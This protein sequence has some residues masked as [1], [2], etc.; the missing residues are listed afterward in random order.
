MPINDC[1]SIKLDNQDRAAVTRGPGKTHV[2]Q[3][4]DRNPTITQS[5][6]LEMFTH[7]NIVRIG[8]LEPGSLLFTEGLLCSRPWEGSTCSL[9]STVKR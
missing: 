7:V 9:K 2:R 6:N 8:C 5:M 3:R 4:G 1:V